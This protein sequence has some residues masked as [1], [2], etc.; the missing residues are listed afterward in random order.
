MPCNRCKP[1]GYEPEGHEQGELCYGFV[2]E[3]YGEKYSYNHKGN[4]YVWFGE[5]IE[6]YVNDNGIIGLAVNDPLKVEETV[7]EN[8]KLLEFDE[9]MKVYEKS[10][11]EALN[12]STMFDSMLT[13]TEEGAKESEI[14][15]YSFKID[16]ITLRYTRITEEKEFERALL[17]PVWS[18]SGTCY[19]DGKAVTEGSFLEINAVDGTVYNSMIGN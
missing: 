11:L 6:V 9:I 4:K 10:Q 15:H 17:V 3:D 13:M 1:V 7:V 14:P 5:G 2:L 16:D 12:Q 19:A 8:G 18:F